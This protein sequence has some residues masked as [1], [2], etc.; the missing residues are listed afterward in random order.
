[1][2]VSFT[3]ETQRTPRLR[4]AQ[5]SKLS[6]R[7]LWVLCASAV[8]GMLPVAM[9]AV[10]V[11]SGCAKKRRVPLATPPVTG[12]VEVGVASWYGHP[13]H[14]RPSSSGEIYDMEK[15]TAAHRTLP[16]GTLV[17]VRSVDN[18]RSVEVRINDRGPFVEGRII[19]LSRA[20]ARAVQMIGPGIARVRLEVLSLPARIPES[21]FAVQIGAFRQRANAQRL[22]VAIEREYGRAELQVRDGNP[23]LWRVLVGREPI[24]EEAEALAGRLRVKFGA[25]FVVRVD[26]PSPAL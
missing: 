26:A 14:G 10:L 12:A 11:L 6:W 25:A 2:E 17:R 24:Q 5:H 19:D 8:N 20:A 3:A 1:M 13:Y 18:G 23:P 9:A 4:R 21:Y 15:L 7:D 16:F 22:R